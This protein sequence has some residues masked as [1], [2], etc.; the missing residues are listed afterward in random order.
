MVIKIMPLDTQIFTIYECDT[1]EFRSNNV[2]NWIS[3]KKDGKEIACVYK[4][5]V[6]KSE[7]KAQ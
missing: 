1:F 3:L 2:I 7:T 4:V 5:G 6:I